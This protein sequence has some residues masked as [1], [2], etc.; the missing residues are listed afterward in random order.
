[1]TVQISN[2]FTA[3][4]ENIWE[5]LSEQGQGCY[6]PAYQRPY[7]W[8]SDNVDR[9]VD[10]VIN[11]I[12]NLQNRAAAISFMG[13][14]IAIHD[15][16]HITVKPVYKAEVAPRVMTIIDGQQRIS[17]SV[18]INIALHNLIAGLL[19]RF[20]RAEG[21]EFEWIR[22]QS[23]LVLA[24]LWQT[25]A[26]DRTT[27]VPPV[28]RYYPRVIR[29][30]DDVWS[31][32]Q[33][34][35]L[36]RSPIAALIWAYIAHTQNADAKKPAFS[37]RVEKADGSADAR[38]ASVIEVFSYIARQLNRLTGKH[39]DKFDFPNIQQLVAKDEFM[40]ALWSYPASDA[41]KTYLAEGSD[42]RLFGHYTQLLRALIFFKYFC[43]RMALT[44]VTTQ[45]EDDAFDMFEALNTTG[46]P[47]TAYETFRPKIIEAEGLA[48][49]ESSP[50]HIAMERIET[51]LEAYKK[52]D[53]RQKATAELLIPFALAESGVKLQ[54][55]LSDQRRY[56]RDAFDK[57]PTIEEK[58]SAVVSM[59]NL[60]AFMETGWQRP[61]DE[62]P[63]LEGATPFDP[64]TGFCFQALRNLKH[65]ITISGVARFY[66]E[67][68][69]AEA[70]DRPSKVSDL[71][72]AIRATAAFSMLWRGGKGGTENIDGLYRAVLR[73]GDPADS[74]P[75]M[76][77]RIEDVRGVVSLS[78]Y[79]RLLKRR[80]VAEFPTRED[81]VNHASRMAIYSH[82]VSVA[83][84]LILA[85]S[86]DTVID[87]A[88]D[89]EG[90]VAAGRA[91]V[92]PTMTGDAWRSDTLFTVEHIAPQS[93]S[94]GWQED[95][96]EPGIDAVHRLG[97]LTLLPK[98]PNSYVSNKSWPHKRLLYRY[99]SAQT[100]AEA[101]AV[102]SEF[103]AAGL[104]VSKAGDLVLGASP[105]MPMC[106]AVSTVGGDWTL[107]LI[108]K[109]SVR[110]AGLA[111]DRLMPWLD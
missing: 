65:A 46:E 32:R 103:G 62:L 101:D 88:K 27:G 74:I 45:N 16:N 87:T 12:T 8:D 28:Y 29:A 7:A 71:F 37:H 39:A 17:T 9:L 51:Y 57:L 19:A 73:D 47:L 95:I 70:E 104:T 40:S 81:W 20:D 105:F 84:F 3:K 106:A 90:L 109:R 24:E 66:D 94:P 91:G 11:G 35:A 93:Q 72:A 25:F 22:E 54:K 111:W 80:L 58:R 78:N 100:D 67:L 59:G 69:R 63:Q 89:A 102:Y 49:F 53:D 50:S 56:L 108:E 96:Y 1:M 86:H 4:A 97:N 23:Q 36:Y 5:F 41:A 10:D 18:M 82:S 34:Q 6:I 68:R 75:P 21:E 99:F 76:A 31:K 13:T 79:K 42:H 38:H 26:L 107:E 33:N 85:A 83:K 30:F 43:N 15:V 55:T 77:K 61:L 110:L 52:A 92:S 14:I 2:I 44:V 60:A 48:V 98:T 64:S